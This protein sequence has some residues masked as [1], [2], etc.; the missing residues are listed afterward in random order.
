MYFI[1]AGG[2][3]IYASADL[4]SYTTTETRSPANV[5]L[6]EYYN[7]KMFAIT[8]SG[9][10]YSAPFDDPFNWK[11]TNSSFNSFIDIVGGKE[12]VLVGISQFGTVVY[13]KNDGRNW[14]SGVPTVMD[15]QELVSIIYDETAFF[16]VSTTG[17]VF[18]SPTGE[19]RRWELFADLPG[20]KPTKM[21]YQSRLYILVRL[22]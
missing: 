19:V 14:D 1:A 6:V 2:G 22:Q 4:Q 13:S 8:S 15:G 16:A 18:K 17:K 11:W 12:G 3:R 10:L 5:N 20:V 21:Y 7:G 9:S